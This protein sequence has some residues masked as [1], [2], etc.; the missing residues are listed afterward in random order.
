MTKYRREFVHYGGEGQYWCEKSIKMW[1]VTCVVNSQVVNCSKMGI[2]TCW[3]LICTRHLV[4]HSHTEVE[5]RSIINSI[6]SVNKS[7]DSENLPETEKHV[8][9]FQ[10][11]SFKISISGNM[12]R[13][14]DSRQATHTE[15]CNRLWSL[16]DWQRSMTPWPSLGSRGGFLRLRLR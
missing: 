2:A 10:Q 7:A 11:V 12:F 4:A 15:G 6:M 14:G 13:R 16:P 9:W 3:Y 5:K 1:K 8:V